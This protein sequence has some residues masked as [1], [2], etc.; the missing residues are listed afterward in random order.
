MYRLSIFFYFISYF[1]QKLKDLKIKFESNDHTQV[2]VGLQI[3]LEH[4]IH[5]ENLLNQI[6]EKYKEVFHVLPPNMKIY[7]L[8]Q[9]LKEAETPS[10]KDLAKEVLT[11]VFNP[12]KAGKP[13]K[14]ERIKADAEKLSNQRA[15]AIIRKN[16]AK[17]K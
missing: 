1:L 5:V 11:E 8:N 6:L 10:A 3:T 12:D 2:H 4:I 14:S 13:T 15:L 16:R 7:A 17:D 9:K